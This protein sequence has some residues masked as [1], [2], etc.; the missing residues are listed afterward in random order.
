MCA[1]SHLRGL[2]GIIRR[3]MDVK[4]EDTA[5]I[6]TVRR[7][8]RKIVNALARWVASASDACVDGAGVLNAPP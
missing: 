5:R 4:G 7:L 6:R 2:V 3:E 8:R 1:G